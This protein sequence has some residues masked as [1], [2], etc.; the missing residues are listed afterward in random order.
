[1]MVLAFMALG[2]PVVT[3]TLNL[4]DSLSMD[5]RTKRDILENQYCGLAV[6]EYVKYLNL[7]LTRWDSWWETNQDTNPPAGGAA[8]ET[9]TICGQSIT[10]KATRIDADTDD[11]PQ[12]LPVIPALPAYNNRTFQTTKVSDVATASPGEV[13]TYTI[14]VQHRDTNSKKLTKIHDLLPPGFCYQ[15][16]QPGSPSLSITSGTTTTIY[17]VSDP[18]QEPAQCPALGQT[19]KLTWSGLPN[20]FFQTGYFLT[21][22]FKVKPKINIAADNYCNE[23]WVEPGLLDTRSGKTAIIQIGVLPGICDNKAVEISKKVV[24]IRNLALVTPSNP[25]QYSFTVDYS[26][27]VKNIG[28]ATLIIGPKGQTKY[29]LRD[30]LPLGFCYQAPTVYTG[31]TVQGPDPNAGPPKLNIPKGNKSCPDPDTRQQLDWDFTVDLAQGQSATLAYSATANV[32]RGEHWS[33]LLVGVIY[34]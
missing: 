11:P 15:V 13:I 24:N 7:N 19:Q 21:L 25:Q 26:L 10:L 4:A 3:S 17:S 27:T 34:W 20:V 30:L 8:T 5:S 1:M 9:V 28:E 29:G 18:L 32:S 12:G 23:A 33:D 22:S 2:T 31:P 16:G 6:M 14:T